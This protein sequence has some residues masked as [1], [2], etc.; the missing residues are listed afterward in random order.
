MLIFNKIESFIS[1]GNKRSAKAK[2][3]VLS[4]ILVKGGI[5][6]IGL[7][8]VPLT[9]NYVDSERY[10]V[11][12]TLNTMVTWM[13]FFDIGLSNGLKNKLTEALAIKNYQLC[14]EYISTTYALLSIIFIPLMIILLLIAPHIDWTKF[15][16]LDLHSS[17]GL[18]ISICIVITYFCL[19]FI[20]STINT[21][22]LA[23]Q[24]PADASLRSFFQNLFSLIIIYILTITTEGSLINLCLAMCITPLIVVLFFNITL[25]KKRYKYISPSLKHI[26]FSLSNSL[27]KLGGQFFIIQIAGLIQYQM[28]NFLILKYYSANDV[29]IYNIGYRYFSVLNMGWAI[30]I[31]PLWV[32]VTDAI[33]NQEY[34]WIK[35][36]L[37]KYIL[38]WGGAVGIGL[39]MLAISNYVYSFWIG[40]KITI[41]LSLSL[42]IMIYNLQ[43]MYGNIFVNILNGASKLKIQT[44]SSTISPLIFILLCKYFITHN[45]EMH[46]IIIAAIISNFNGIIFAPIQC[47]H[48]F[49]KHV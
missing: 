19:N 4:M 31:T 27:L 35:N 20:L 22:L 39:L 30:L 40:N 45:W 48:F 21:V 41:P 29:T 37:K 24:R 47:Y 16:N 12:M 5:I 49:K 42:W 46:S 18:L 25:F 43:M 14:K 38:I 2:K 15:L 33:V 32:A 3:N 17:E 1:K 6:L 10:G 36:V 28:I 7:I 23:D 11:W 13:S 34:S 26:N 8:L 9:I 44:I